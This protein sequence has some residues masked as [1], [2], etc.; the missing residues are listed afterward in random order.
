MLPHSQPV[1]EPPELAEVGRRVRPGDLAPSQVGRLRHYR[2][3]IPNATPGPGLTHPQPD[4]PDGLYDFG[5][6]L[7]A[8]SR[9]LAEHLHG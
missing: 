6:R 2:R 5:G 7:D 4:L 1:P 8:G 3:R 9:L